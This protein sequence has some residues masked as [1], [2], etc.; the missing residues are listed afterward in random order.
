MLSSMLKRGVDVKESN[1]FLRAAIT[2]PAKPI[3]NVKCWTK[4]EDATTPVLP[5]I[6]AI[7]STTGRNTK[8][9]EIISMKYFSKIL[10]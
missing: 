2:A 10:I 6:L 8:K 5:K 9:I 4:T 7:T 1:L 3:H